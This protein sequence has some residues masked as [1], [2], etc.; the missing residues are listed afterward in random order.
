[1]KKTLK[2]IVLFCLTTLIALSLASCDQ[3][4][5]MLPSMGDDTKT[6]TPQ[7]SLDQTTPLETTSSNSTS[8]ETT[9]SETTSNAPESEE[10]IP[11]HN[12]HAFGPWV[13]VKEASKLEE[14]LQ[15]RTCSCGEKET[16]VI[17]ATGS[18]GLAYKINEDGTTCTITGMGSCTDTEIII[19]SAIDGYR[20]TIIGEFAFAKPNN[21]TSIVMPNSV[22]KVE[23]CAFN[24]CTKLL[25]VTFGASVQYMGD[26]LFSGCENLK[27]ITVDSKNEKYHSKNNCLIE[28]AKKTLVVGGNSSIIPTDGSVTRIGD[29]AFDGRKT[30]TNITIPNGVV[31]IGRYAFGSCQGLTS[32]TMPDSVTTLLR[33]AFYNCTNLSGVTFSN[34]LRDVI[35]EGAFMDCHSLESVTLPDSLINVG[36]YMFYRCT[37]LSNV[38]LG[39]SVQHIG[40]FAFYECNNLSTISIPDSLESIGFSVFDTCTNLDYN[41]YENAYYLGNTT[42]PYV[43]LMKVVSTDNTSYTI[44]E[45]TKI[46]HE[47][48]FQYCENLVSITIPGNVRCIG[49]SAFS[50]CSNLLTVSLTEGLISI[51][52]STFYNCGN[53]ENFLIPSSVINVGSTAF[54]GCDKLIENDNGILYIDKW[55]V[56]Y[57]ISYNSPTTVTLRSG[58]AGIGGNAFLEYSRLKSIAIPSSV[59]SISNGAFQGCRS[60][61]DITIPSNVKNIGDGAFQGCSSLTNITLPEG[62]TYIGI[63]TFSACYKLVSIVIPNSVTDIR[64]NAF[65]NCSQLTDVT[66]PSSVTRFGDIAFDRCGNLT[67]FTYE[68]TMEQWYAIEKESGWCPHIPFTIHCTDGNIIITTN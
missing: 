12:T 54:Y 40:N 22:T 20:T 3:L 26:D 38:T 16:Q 48:A 21:I 44:H 31:T 17:P 10:T 15:E 65:S 32:I 36:E 28:T 9:P 35:G 18:V 37:K 2:I 51:G 46:I 11:P 59:K 5:S 42:N 27:T 50:F 64:R 68:G 1:M 49:T 67:S 8:E 45:D 62:I 60:L 29:F 53:L 34:S 24:N 33:H 39:N 6:T 41:V 55:V 47:C 23:W 25:S 66:I 13:T 63:E 19:P 57:N 30:L 7:Q 58:T 43:V 4:L 56:G 14:G 61:T 52:D